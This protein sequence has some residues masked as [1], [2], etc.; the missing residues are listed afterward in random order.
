M[1]NSALDAKLDKLVRRHAELSEL[2]A[3]GS[4]NFAKLSKEY[5]E[6]APVV[7]SVEALKG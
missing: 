4:G 5:S 7:E 1:T 2:M 3:T 6:L